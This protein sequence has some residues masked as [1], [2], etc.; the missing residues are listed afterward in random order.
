MVY[1][2]AKKPVL[3]AVGPIGFFESQRKILTRGNRITVT[4]SMVT[5][6]DTPIMIATTIEE[7]NEELQLRDKEGRPFWMGWKKVK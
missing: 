5:V 6:D 4:G 1:T 7:G 2:E 3:V